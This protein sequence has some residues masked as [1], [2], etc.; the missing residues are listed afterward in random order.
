[1]TYP[2]TETRILEMLKAGFN[3]SSIAKAVN[4]TDTDIIHFRA[5]LMDKEPKEVRKDNRTKDDLANYIRAKVKKPLASLTN[6][7]K[8]TLLEL[9]TCIK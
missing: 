9:A 5:K 2:S 3:I 7:T 8:S 1:M 4:L 6:L